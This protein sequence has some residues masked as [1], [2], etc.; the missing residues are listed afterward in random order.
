MAQPTLDIFQEGLMRGGANLAFDPEKKYFYVEHPTEGWRV[1]LR[2]CCFIHQKD[3]CVNMDTFVVVKRTGQ[4]ANEKAW[5]PPKGQMEFKDHSAKK[6][7]APVIE[8]LK[9]NVTR[10]V[11]EESRITDLKGLRHTGLV[12]QGRES[13]YP[14]N[15]YFQYH[16]FQAVVMPEEYTKA[17]EELVWYKEH[18][19]AFARLRRDKREKDEIAWFSPSEHR[20][21]GKWS[22][23]IVALYLSFINGGKN[24]SGGL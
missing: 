17:S 2:S 7:N 16:I 18:P 3:K 13:S 5:E 12:F 4:P 14:P 11:A 19:K 15:H 8:L 20:L 21:M 23:K 6:K 24:Q 22:P 1:Y 9:E 10:E